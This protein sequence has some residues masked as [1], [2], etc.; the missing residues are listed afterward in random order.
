MLTSSPQPEVVRREESPA[1]AWANWKCSS[2]INP[3]LPVYCCTSVNAWAAG[4]R[5]GDLQA[6]EQGKGAGAALAKHRAQGVGE[7]VPVFC[8]HQGMN[9]APTAGAGLGF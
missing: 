3:L 1:R 5:C 9:L 2:G 7:A 8:T 4:A 6:G